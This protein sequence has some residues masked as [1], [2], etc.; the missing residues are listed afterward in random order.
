MYIND[1]IIHHGSL[2]TTKTAA[3]RHREHVRNCVKDSRAWRER[4]REVTME[5]VVGEMIAHFG[6]APTSENRWYAP[7]L[8]Q[9]EPVA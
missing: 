7:R 2:Y 6:E 8:S 1:E 3:D 5:E 9:L 4:S